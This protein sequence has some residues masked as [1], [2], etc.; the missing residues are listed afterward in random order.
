MNL[1]TVPPLSGIGKFGDYGGA[2][3]ISEADAYSKE[4]ASDCE[5]CVPEC[6]GL[7][8]V[9]YQSEEGAD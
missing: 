7:D 5:L 3:D 4:R 2:G 6:G 8:N 1:R 9:S